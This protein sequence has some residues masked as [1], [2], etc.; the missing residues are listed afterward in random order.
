VGVALGHEGN[1]VSFEIITQCSRQSFL[2]NNITDSDI[3]RA[4]RTASRA[5]HA[6]HDLSEND[7]VRSLA[8]SVQQLA[9]A[10]EQLMNELAKLKGNPN[11]EGQ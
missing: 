4:V 11:P 5:A 7:A 6:A 2:M 10:M 8:G 3:K 1:C 9:F